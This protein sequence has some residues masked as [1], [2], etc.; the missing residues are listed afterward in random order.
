M[1][2][3]VSKLLKVM[4]DHFVFCA[5]AACRKVI[6]IPFMSTCFSYSHIWNQTVNCTG[7]SCTSVYVQLTWG[8]MLMHPYPHRP[9]RAA[10]AHY[11]SIPGKRALYTWD[12][13]NIIEIFSSHTAWPPIWMSLWKNYLNSWTGLERTTILLA[14]DCRWLRPCARITD[15]LKALLIVSVTFKE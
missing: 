9:S 4:Q 7:T 8:E 2:F 13:L 10:I 5:H 11:I 14:A 6:N 3:V 12:N 1:T 15:L